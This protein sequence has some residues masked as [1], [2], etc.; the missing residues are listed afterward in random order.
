M[1][2][3]GLHAKRQ[4]L[5]AVAARW[6]RN[7][8]EGARAE[9]HLAALRAAD[10]DERGLA[11]ERQGADRAE[12][13]A[14]AR[15]SGRRRRRESRGRRR[16]RVEVLAH[17]RHVIKVVGR[18]LE[19]ELR[20]FLR[21]LVVAVEALAAGGGGV[22]VARG[23]SEDAA[24]GLE[25][26]LQVREPLVGSIVLA[27]LEV[28]PERRR[29]PRPR[30]ARGTPRTDLAASRDGAPWGVGA[31][32][33]TV[34]GLT[35]SSPSK[36]S[37]IILWKRWSVRRRTFWATAVLFSSNVGTHRVPFRW[38]P[39]SLYDTSVRSQRETSCRPSVVAPESRLVVSET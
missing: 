8:V 29:S 38:P 25:L 19:R 23:A 27:A 13:G 12:A 17:A 14:P 3:L 16:A 37:V 39:S 33:W 9:R 6:T 1:V 22:V 21:V 15:A 35:L 24:S 32:P 18:A 10:L 2:P 28:V 31:S 5:Q 4:V 26:R 36:T 30:S 34:M 11:V 7:D 20:G